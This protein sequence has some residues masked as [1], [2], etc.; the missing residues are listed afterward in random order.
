MGGVAGGPKEGSQGGRV[1]VRACWA[2]VFRELC[3]SSLG[4]VLEP[5]IIAEWTLDQL[6]L[7]TCKKDE[8]RGGGVRPID[9]ASARAQ[10]LIPA[11]ARVPEGGSLA[12]EARLKMERRIA[13]ERAAAKKARREER[14]RKRRSKQ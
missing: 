6:Y 5:N 10:G 12:S 14:Q 1:T 13:A 4:F 3:E 2:R 11:R 7:M 8:L 9:P